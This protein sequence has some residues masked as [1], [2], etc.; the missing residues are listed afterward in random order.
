MTGRT[1]ATARKGWAWMIV[2]LLFALLLLG[3]G[4]SCWFSACMRHSSVHGGNAR[5]GGPAR[6]WF[7]DPFRES[8]N[9]LHSDLTCVSATPAP[10]QMRP[11]RQVEELNEAP[12]RGGR[13]CGNAR[14]LGRVL[15]V[16]ALH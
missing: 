16:L 5:S 14:V 8:G 10:A 9:A 11:T 1:T 6:S 3:A 15:V 12:L 7:P 2:A 4:E 13:G